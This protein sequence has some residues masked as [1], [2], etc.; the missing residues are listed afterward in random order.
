MT[1]GQKQEHFAK[2]VTQLLV[3][4]HI[5]G[6]RIRFGHAFRCTNC[7]A[8]NKN[9][10]HKLKLAIDLNLFKDGKYLTSTEDHKQLGEFWE[11]LGGAWGGRFNDGN[12]YSLEHDGRK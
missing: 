12:H 7:H 10:L 11:S 4:A 9:S 3:F 2:M 5:K 6:Y 1:L 8:G